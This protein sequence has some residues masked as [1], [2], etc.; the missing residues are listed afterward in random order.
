MIS[1]FDYGFKKKILFIFYLIL[2]TLVFLIYDDYGIHIEEKFHRSNGLYWLNYV[3]NLFGFSEIEQ[4]TKIKLQEISD[5]SL[6]AVTHYNKYGILLDLPAALIEIMFKIDD[7]KDVYYL[8]HILSYFLFILSS[9]FFFKILQKR[10]NNFL[11]SFLGLFLY[12]TTPRIFGDSFL[13]KDVLFLSFFCINFYFLIESLEKFNYKNLFIFSIFC[14]FSINLR[15]FAILVPLVFI[16]LVLIKNSNV[17][18]FLENLKKIFFFISILLISLYFFWPYLWSDPLNNFFELFTSAKSD[19]INIKILYD[20][21]FISNRLLPDSYIL[22]WI[23]ITSPT[24]QII[25]FL[26][27]YLYCLLRF[28]RRFVKIKDEPFHNDLWRGSKEQLD[29]VFLLFFT[30]YYFFFI[31]LN[32]PLYNGWRLVYFLNIFLIYFTI[33]FLFNFKIIYKV[34]NFAIKFIAFFLITHNIYT[35]IKMHPFQSLYFS[36]LASKNSYE[37]D[38]H[39]ISTKNFYEKILK[40]DKSKIIKVAVASHTPIQRGLESIPKIYRGTFQIVGQEYHLSDYIY[41]NN[42]SEVN[43]K[44]IKKYQVPENFNKIYELKIDK[45]VIYEIYKRTKN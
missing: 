16:F 11:F 34:K 9:L 36:S 22:N 15:F 13:Y 39:G 23:L 6:S 17:E 27:G 40:E 19:L 35:L 30:L 33:N 14:S 8:K 41:K 21:E 32:A 43:S 31:L 37:G 10:F 26:I 7:V 28:L 4:I 1:M 44:L 2:I 45:L 38:Y 25:F 3:S 18:K 24:L 42:I 5:Y 29:F 20:S 12:I